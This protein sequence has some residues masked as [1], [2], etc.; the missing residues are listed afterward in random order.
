MATPKKQY[1][2]IDEY[3][4]S[5]SEEDQELLQQIRQAIKE[6]APEAEEA[7][8]Y[9]LPAFKLHG[10][11]VYF[12]TYKKHIGFY[13]TPSP[14]ELFAEELAP[15]VVSKGAIQFPKDQPLP[16]DLIRRIVQHRIQENLA[17]QKDRKK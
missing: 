12:A 15:Y 3:I 7:I 5:A 2:T 14:I 1:T 9:Q 17:K 4:A 13:P 8:S 10:N 6:A 11:L 16:L